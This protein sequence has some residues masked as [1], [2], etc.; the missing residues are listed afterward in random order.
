MSKIARSAPAVRARF[1]ASRP[2]LARNTSCPSS[3]SM[4]R[5][6]KRMI[7]SS[8]ATIILNCFTLRPSNSSVVGLRP[9]AA[10]SR[11]GG[12]LVQRVRQSNDRLRA[13]RAALESDF[14]MKVVSHQRLDDL[15]SQARRA[16]SGQSDA[17]VADG[18]DVGLWPAP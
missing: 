13:V 2:L 11:F 17:V 15:Q 12:Y 8:S 16:T 3:V 4:T 6:P 14:T 5:K 10:A 1:K 7:D 18:D 9:F